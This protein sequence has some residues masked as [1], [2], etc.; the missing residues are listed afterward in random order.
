MLSFTSIIII[1]LAPV[2]LATRVALK[3]N[4]SKADR[5]LTATSGRCELWVDRGG[6]FEGRPFYI[7]LFRVPSGAQ[8]Q[9]GPAGR[10]TPHSTCF[11]R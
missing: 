7:K 10:S 8:S 4:R 11:C 5:R 9:S 6:R 2:P 1:E 3:L